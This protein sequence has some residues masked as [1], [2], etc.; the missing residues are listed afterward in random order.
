MKKSAMVATAALVAATS[1]LLL[2]TAAYAFAA[3]IHNPDAAYWWDGMMG[4]LGD[5]DA[6]AGMDGLY[7]HVRE[8]T[9][10]A[11]ASGRAASYAI[12]GTSDGYVAYGPGRAGGG[13]DSGAYGD[14]GI[15]AGWPVPLS[16]AVYVSSSGQHLPEITHTATSGASTFHKAVSVAP[17][18]TGLTAPWDV[19][20]GDNG[21][22]YVSTRPGVLYG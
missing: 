5:S 2:G 14:G 4:A 18:L 11:D 17:V 9:Y 20:F 1:V 16:K 7:L 6:W 10:G 3:A 12:T 21:W 15:Q 19:A 22:V 13:T 8:P